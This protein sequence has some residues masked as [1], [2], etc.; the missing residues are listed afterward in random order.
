MRTVKLNIDILEQVNGTTVNKYFTLK[1]KSGSVTAMMIPSSSRHNTLQPVW[2]ITVPAKPILLMQGLYHHQ[3]TGLYLAFI[4]WSDM[5]PFADPNVP[6][7]FEENGGFN[8]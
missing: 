2:Q 5:S 1:T 3:D 8:S 4:N 6:D 7:R